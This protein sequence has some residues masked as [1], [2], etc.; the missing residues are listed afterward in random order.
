MVRMELQEMSLQSP[1]PLG[2]VA[3]HRT[4]K[5]GLRVAL[6]PLMVF[7]IPHVLVYLPTVLAVEH[8]KIY[9]HSLHGLVKTI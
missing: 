7:E 8:L 6:E 2:P 1:F 3:A 9:R 5:H 4:R